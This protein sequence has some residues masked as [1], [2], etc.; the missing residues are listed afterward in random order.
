MAS[1]TYNVNI[2]TTTIVK[3]VL[4]GLAIW[5]LTAIS[6]VLVVIFVALVLAAAI[7]PWI[8]RL[9]HLGM[10]RGWAMAIIFI[11]AAALLSLIVILF[12]P[13]VVDQ[14]GQ[15]TQAFPKLYEKVFTLYQNN[16]GSVGLDT[17]Q[18]GLQNL[19]SALTDVTKGIFSSVFGFFGGLFS[20]IGVL[21]LTFYMTLEEKGMK[22]I[23]VDLTPAKY[24]PYFIQ[25]FNRIEDR[26]GDWL[27]GQL[28]LGLII[29]L[30]TLV[31]LLLLKVKFAVVLAL[32]AGLTELI[33]I[34]GPFIG[35][36]PAVIVAFSQDPVLSLFVMG[37][38]LVI[39]QLENNLI[40]P[41][42]M[43]KATGLNPVIVLVSILVGGNLAGITGVI[44]AVPT[45][46]IITTFLEDFLEEKK[47]DALRLEP[48]PKT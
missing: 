25:L 36:I 46:I 35:A 17:I 34:I 43:S 9:E 40:V 24:R 45:I 3:I 15:F 41:R 31:G 47:A 18:K 42:V 14:L 16:Q 10:Q 6:Q 28:I 1:Q 48:T 21:V 29:G 37:L 7:D 39:Q 22:R 12:V 4:V 8:T 27:R 32:I 13:L 20:V 23:A 19:N 30:L 26:L 38:Y 5:F 33:P 44:L 2:S 11:S